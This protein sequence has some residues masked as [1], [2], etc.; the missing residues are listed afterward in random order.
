ML[1]HHGVGVLRN[2]IS[3]FADGEC[4]WSSIGEIE[5][6]REKS[7]DS[8]SQRIYLFEKFVFTLGDWYN[9]FVDTVF[10]KWQ[11]ITAGKKEVPEV[12]RYAESR[13]V[14]THT[15]RQNPF[16][17]ARRVPA[18]SYLSSSRLSYQ[19]SSKLNESV[20]DAAVDRPYISISHLS[21]VEFN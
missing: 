12:R 11:E 16:W 1:Y 7:S 8:V 13:W 14:P 19:L 2:S 9:S 17:G 10:T 5:S 6:S 21:P 20:Q 4:G 3:D 15:T 18:D